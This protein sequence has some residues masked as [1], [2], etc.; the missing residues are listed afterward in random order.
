MSIFELF[1]YPII[2]GF[3]ITIIL[4]VGLSV[5]FSFR[6]Y[7]Q[8]HKITSMLDLVTTMANELQLIRNNNNLENINFINSSA[9]TH[10]NSGGTNKLIEVSDDDVTDD[11]CDDDVTDD[12]DESDNDVTDD[13]DY[14]VTDDESDN[15]VT[16][17]D[18]ILDNN[19]D[20]SQEIHNSDIKILK[21]NISNDSDYLE[22]TEVDLNTDTIE[23]SIDQDFNNNITSLNLAETINIDM[24]LEYSTP[25]LEVIN[26]DILNQEIHPDVLFEHNN[27]ND[28]YKKMSLSKLRSLVEQK[29]L[30][31][32]AS[33][34]KKNDILKLLEQS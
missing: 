30:V 7:E 3:S 29:G 1:S 34:L 26:S 17:I 20:I 18:I 27:E 28:D 9:A 5:Y 19:F 24:P 25:S 4:V 8:D 21:L 13:D 23:Q 2:L 14:N 10:V 15:D 11:E 16:D 6:I 31:N 22:Q 12:D 33:K 32:D